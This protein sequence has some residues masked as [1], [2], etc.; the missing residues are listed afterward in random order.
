VLGVGVLE[1]VVVAGDIGGIEVANNSSGVR[2]LS[3]RSGDA[4]E[5]QETDDDRAGCTELHI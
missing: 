4:K 3:P 5:W 1:D 2:L